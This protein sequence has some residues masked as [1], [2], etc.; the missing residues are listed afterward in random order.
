MFIKTVIQRVR[1]S[2]LKFFLA[3]SLVLF[4]ATGCGG[5]GI[6]TVNSSGDMG[7]FQPRRRLLPGRLEFRER[8]LRAAMEEADALAGIQTIHF[9]LP[10]D[11]SY[12][13]PLS[14]LPLIS[15]EVIIDGTSQPGF[16]GG[17]PIVHVDGSSM[18]AATPVSGFYIMDNIHATIKG[19][20]I[21][22]FP[23]HGIENYGNLTLDHLEIAVNQVNG[24]EFLQIFRDARHHP[25]QFHD[26]R[27]RRDGNKRDQREFHHGLRIV[28]EEYRGR[29]PGDRRRIRIGSRHH[30]R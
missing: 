28:R 21:L 9:N 8:T 2:K 18:P 22:R 12:I 25:Q 24:I 27:E 30:R 14:L 7:D 20:Q 1:L 6:F 15:D 17:K 3:V 23:G 10:A 13:Y 16:D 5:G 26:L 4:L 29:H 19:L 11:D